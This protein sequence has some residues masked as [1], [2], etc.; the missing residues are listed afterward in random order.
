MTII[1]NNNQLAS[2]SSSTTSLTMTINNNNQLSSSSSTTT[3]S[4]QQQQRRGRH[5]C[6]VIWPSIVLG[7]VSYRYSTA[8]LISIRQ[9]FKK[10][11]AKGASLL[12]PC[13]TLFELLQEHGHTQTTFQ[14]FVRSTFSSGGSPVILHAIILAGC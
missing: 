10:G 9:K 3:C 1:N 5:T 14:G 11:R 6:M 13:S 2:S 8:R 7:R 12:A 4:H